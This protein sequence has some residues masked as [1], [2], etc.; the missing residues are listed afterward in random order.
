MRTRS[1]KRPSRKHDRKVLMAEESTKSWADTDS[2]S[3]SSS[4]SS[5]DS[6]QEE[7]HCLMAD[8]TS[9]DENSH[10]LS[11]NGKAGI[12]FSKPESSKSSWLKNR[13]D[14]DKAKAGRNP[15][16]PN[17]PW[18]SSTKVKSGWTK[19][20]PMRDLNGQKMKSKLNRSHCN[21]A[22]TFKDT[23]TGKT[24]TVAGLGETPMHVGVD[25]SLSRIHRSQTCVDICYLRG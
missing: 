1:D 13:L 22:Q 18:R 3:S 17:Q 11:D 21:Y 6:E 8:Q 5:S 24:V 9:D 14:K 12:G 7:V 20:Q 4:S 10:K 19:N 16:F 25:A 15:F 2:E 23:Y